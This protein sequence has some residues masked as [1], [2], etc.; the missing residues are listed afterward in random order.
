MTNKVQT[1][2]APFVGSRKASGQ[3]HCS[4]AKLKPRCQYSCRYRQLFCCL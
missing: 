1:P 4:F 2:A 3:S